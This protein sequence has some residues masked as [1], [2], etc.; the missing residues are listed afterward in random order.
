ML[1]RRIEIVKNTSNNKNESCFYSVTIALFLALGCGFCAVERYTN[2][3]KVN[4]ES[5]G[6]K[7]NQIENSTNSSS[8]NSNYL[9]FDYSKIDYSKTFDQTKKTFDQTK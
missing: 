8:N 2:P 9:P 1:K 6:K 3:V 7:Q 4:S 5:L